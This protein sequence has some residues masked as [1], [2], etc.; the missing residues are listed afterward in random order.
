MH[1]FA[2]A[3]RKGKKADK[4]GTDKTSEETSGK[5]CFEK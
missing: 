5:N 3:A 4:K 1:L 2:T